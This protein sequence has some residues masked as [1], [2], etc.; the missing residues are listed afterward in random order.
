[1]STLHNTTSLYFNCLRSYGTE[2]NE[3]EWNW[4][5][6]IRFDSTRMAKIPICP[7]NIRRRPDLAAG[8]EQLALWVGTSQGFVLLVNL[9]MPDNEDNRI[10]QLQ[11][12]NAEPIRKCF[13]LEPKTISN[14]FLYIMSPNPSDNLHC[15]CLRT[16]TL[17]RVAQAA[18]KLPG[19]ILHLSCFV[20]E[21]S[22]STQTSAQVTSGPQ[23]STGS[24]ESDAQSCGSVSASN[25]SS[26]A[27][28]RQTDSLGGQANE[29]RK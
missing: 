29:P 2:R 27:A 18:I 4:I 6:S 17:G 7:T 16:F 11:S 14:A 22:K 21:P 19:A 24:L 9:T 25:A 3:T 20:L 13:C 12:V 23:P 26:G 15:I 8:S 5:D 10:L 28:L 1:M